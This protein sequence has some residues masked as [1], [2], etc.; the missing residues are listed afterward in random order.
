M[1]LMCLELDSP[2]FTMTP[3]NAASNLVELFDS[4][5]EDHVVELIERLL[6]HYQGSEK[7]IFIV[8]GVVEFYARM[9]NT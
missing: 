2:P 1:C 6:D 9:L 7:S 3:E 4:E 8:N 5:S